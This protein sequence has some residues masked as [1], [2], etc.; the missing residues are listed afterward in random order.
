MHAAVS[1][2]GKRAIPW[3]V[4]IVVLFCASRLSATEQ[5]MAGAFALA[6]PS[7]GDSAP[8]GA[9]VTGSPTTSEDSSPQK[10]QALNDQNNQDSQGGTTADKTEDK[11]KGTGQSP[12]LDTVMVETKTKVIINR[13]PGETVEP[14]KKEVEVD[15]EAVTKTPAD[16]VKY[17]CHCWMKDDFKEMYRVLDPAASQAIG[18]DAFL[19]RYKSDAETTLGLAGAKLLDEGKGSGSST[20]CRVELYFRNERV[21]ARKITALLRSTA[22]GYRVLESGLIPVDMNDM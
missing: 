10:P 17:F 15:L 9:D 22:R 7:A 11:N 2:I 16:T 21:P 13:A 8:S 6:I 14:K 19:K 20:Q 1:H 3:L 18:F 4:A 12:T 5:L